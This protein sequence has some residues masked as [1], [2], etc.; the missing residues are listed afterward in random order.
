MFLGPSHANL[1]LAETVTNSGLLCSSKQAAQVQSQ[2]ALD[3]DLQWSPSYEVP[4][5]TYL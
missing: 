1:I 3:I 4:E 5:P 2:A